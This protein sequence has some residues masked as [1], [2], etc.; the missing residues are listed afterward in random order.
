MTAP[1][2]GRQHPDPCADC[3]APLVLRDS[4]YGLFYGCTAW[5]RTGC[6]G[7]VG[8]HPDG[9]PL[10][11]P[12]N[13]EVR[14]ARKRAHEAFDEL[15]RGHN[16]RMRREEAYAW[17]AEALGVDEAHIGW[18]TTVEECDR[19]VVLVADR[20]AQPA[21]GASGTSGAALR[22]GRPSP[23]SPRTG[24]WAQT[25]SRAGGSRPAHCVF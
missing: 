22:G 12:V 21:G 18:L 16:A 3:G 6:P 2:L 19:V 1:A 5:A 17:L 7:G 15:W 11:P 9:T 25:L 14:A 23:I 24:R 8:A 20:I 4:R 13:A 10:G